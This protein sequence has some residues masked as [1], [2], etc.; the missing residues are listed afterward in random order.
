MLPPETFIE[1]DMEMSDRVLAASHLGFLPGRANFRQWGVAIAAVLGG[2][3]LLAG[4]LLPWFSLYAGLHT[5]PGVMSITGQA[6]AAGGVASMLA[7]MV[8]LLKDGGAV[9]W[10]LGIM[11]AGLLGFAVWLLIGLLELHRELASNP[12]MIP[13]LGP[14]LFV[15]TAGAFLVASTL[16]FGLVKS[17]SE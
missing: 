2:G 5:Y 16:L 8:V 11:G 1:G 14:G 12:M 9:R 3:L 10:G 17:R 6:L 15:A 13:E 7:G 4:A